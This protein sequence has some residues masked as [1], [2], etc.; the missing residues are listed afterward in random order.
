METLLFNVKIEH[1]KNFCLE[2]ND[3]YIG[4]DDLENG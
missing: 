2:K 1:S 3:K 4:Q